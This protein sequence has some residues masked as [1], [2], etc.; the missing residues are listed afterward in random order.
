VSPGFF[1]DYATNATDGN[2][3]AFT[4]AFPS[5]SSLLKKTPDFTNIAFRKFR[6][7]LSLSPCYPFWFGAA[8]VFI[9]L[10]G[11]STLSHFPHV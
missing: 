7:P 2:P 4:E 8:S 1:L 9:P 10:C 6:V 5:K 3:E 11:S